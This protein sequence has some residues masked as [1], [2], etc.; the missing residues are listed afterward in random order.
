MKANTFFAA[1]FIG[2]QKYYPGRY[3]SYFNSLETS[4]VSA[5]TFRNII[6]CDCK[7]DCVWT[8]TGI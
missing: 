1:A 8:N 6:V 2:F 5:Y 7:V 4:V 3:V